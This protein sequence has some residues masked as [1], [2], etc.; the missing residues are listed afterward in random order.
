MIDEMDEQQKPLINKKYIVY[1]ILAALG[2]AILTIVMA[3]V[4]SRFGNVELGVVRDLFIIALAMEAC[5]F[6]VALI[7]LIVMIIRLINTVE[8]EVKPVIQKTNE[9]ISTAKGTTDFVSENVVKPTTQVRKTVKGVRAGA[10]ALL[11]DPKKN[12]PK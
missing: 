1:G 11:R 7:I 5:V 6:G 12:M 8:Y 10:S 4:I 3:W 2:L 9:I